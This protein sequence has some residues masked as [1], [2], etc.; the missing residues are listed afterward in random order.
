[1]TVFD[2]HREDDFDEFCLRFEGLKIEIEYP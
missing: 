1:M 2:E